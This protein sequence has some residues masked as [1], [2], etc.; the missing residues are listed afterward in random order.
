MMMIMM[1]CWWWQVTGS[2]GCIICRHTCNTSDIW[3]FLWQMYVCLC[4]CRCMTLS[5]IYRAILTYIVFNMLTRWTNVYA[6]VYWSIYVWQLVIPCVSGCLFM[7][8]HALFDETKIFVRFALLMPALAHSLASSLARSL[9][10]TQPHNQRIT[11]PNTPNTHSFGLSITQS[12]IHSE[13]HPRTHLPTRLSICVYRKI[14][15][16]IYRCTDT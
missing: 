2:G 16:Y 1:L 13:T 4:C 10:L 5:I 8:M 12:F 11:Q 3:H 9:T 14:H 15:A 7:Y 6:S